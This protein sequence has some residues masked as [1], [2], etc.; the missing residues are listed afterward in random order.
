[1]KAEELQ[2]RVKEIHPWFYEMDLGNGVITPGVGALSTL[3]ARAEIYFNM[4]IKGSSVLD[5]GAWDGYYSFEAERR[6]ATRVLAVDKFCWGGGGEGKRAAF[7]LA[8]EALGS[9]VEDL[10]IDIPETTIEKVGQFDVVLFNGI[11]YHIKDPLHALADMAKIARHVLSVETFMD[12][13][14]VS[15]PAMV[16]YPGETAEPGFPRN[17]WGINSSLGHALLRSLGFESVLE[18]PTPENPEHRSIFLAFKPGHPYAEFVQSNQAFAKPRLTSAPGP[19]QL[20]IAAP[21]LDTDAL[22]R[23]LSANVSEA[24][25]LDADALVRTI[26]ANT[27][28]TVKDA[29]ATP[30]PPVGWRAIAKATRHR[31]AAYLR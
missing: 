6:G 26:L 13:K 15:R 8:R 18:F 10:I 5:V 9:R 1:M 3:Q 11:L 14:D 19:T 24:V 31:I 21:P 2:R 22:A 4:G 27:R 16:F 12:L 25:K 7:E 30:P 17:G 28:E 20:P 29:M 23:T